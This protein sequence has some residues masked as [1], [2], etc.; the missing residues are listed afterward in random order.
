MIVACVPS[1]N[2]PLYQVSGISPNPVTVPEMLV[3]R[4]SNPLT[5]P[6]ESAHASLKTENSLMLY[7]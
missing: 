5:I 3:T 4:A 6:S 7:E 2:G 1:N